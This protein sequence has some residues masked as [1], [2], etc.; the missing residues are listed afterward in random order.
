MVTDGRH[1]Y[2]EQ[3]HASGRPPAPGCCGWAALGGDGVL[4]VAAGDLDGA[5]LALL[6]DGDG[7]GEDARR[8]VGGDV[9][10]ILWGARSLHDL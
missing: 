5:V 2:A 4:S 10:G 3:G 6:A 8:V 1:G 9:L 7:Q